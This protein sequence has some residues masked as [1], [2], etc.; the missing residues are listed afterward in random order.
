MLRKKKKKHRKTEK[1]AKPKIE[2]TKMED[3]PTP[4]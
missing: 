1:T 3:S 2:A 4:G